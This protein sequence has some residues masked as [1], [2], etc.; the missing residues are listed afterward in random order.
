MRDYI[1]L[2]CS[3]TTL[4]KTRKPIQVSGMVKCEIKSIQLGIIH[5]ITRVI[6]QAAGLH[7]AYPGTR[8]SKM[9]LS[10]IGKCNASKSFKVSLLWFCQL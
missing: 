9:S 6:A 4:H 7:T 3:V 2:Y 1:L 5:K 10:E 8:I